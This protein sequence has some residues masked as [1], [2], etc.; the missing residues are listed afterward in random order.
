MKAAGT[1]GDA[2]AAFSGKACGEGADD[3]GTGPGALNGID[4]AFMW[5]GTNSAA[6][7]W[8]IL[9]SAQRTKPMGCKFVTTEV[10]DSLIIIR[11]N[12]SA[13]N[14]ITINDKNITHAFSHS[15]VKIVS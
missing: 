3:R 12:N 11:Y 5:G 7:F 14:N 15:P 8:W 4:M 10:K 6:T 9:A 1:Y 13:Y 2:G